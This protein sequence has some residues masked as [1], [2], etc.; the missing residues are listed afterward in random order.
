MRNIVS[1]VEI[2]DKMDIITIVITVVI[3]RYHCCGAVALTY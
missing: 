2:C 1:A 3:A